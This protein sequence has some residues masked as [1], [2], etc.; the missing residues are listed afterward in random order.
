VLLHHSAASD[1]GK[2]L[3]KPYCDEIISI[4]HL[5]ATH[6]RPPDFPK[7]VSP[8]N[9]AFGKNL[10]VSSVMPGYEGSEKYLVD[11]VSAQDNPMGFWANDPAKEKTSSIVIDLDKVVDVDEIRLQFRP[12]DG[13]YWFVPS[14]ISFSVSSY[15]TKFDPISI[16]YLDR[17]GG[18]AG[19]YVNTTCLPK[20]NS[21]YN[22]QLWRYKIA[23]GN[24]KGRY[25]RIDLGQSQRIDEPYKGTLEL[26]EIEIAETGK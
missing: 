23:G 15:G 16:M 26:T 25:I 10:T 4:C 2:V 3:L 11:G 8:D 14:S 21:T 17:N 5:N 9:I 22:S 7:P 24:C 19:P 1:E 20:E 18:E 6:L 12:I 13:K